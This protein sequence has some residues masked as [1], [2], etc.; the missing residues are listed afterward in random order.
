MA[1]DD[2][3]RDGLP[4]RTI[5]KAAA[6]RYPERRRPA[7]RA[8]MSL[9][10]VLAICVVMVPVLL[11]NNGRNLERLGD[12]VGLPL[13]DWWRGKMQRVQRPQMLQPGAQPVPQAVDATGPSRL[14]IPTPA[15]DTPP[16]HF[17]PPAEAWQPEASCNALQPGA[18]GEKPVFRAAPDG[19]SECTV[20]IAL[21]EGDTASSLFLQVRAVSDR[22]SSLRMK[23]NF[24]MDDQAGALAQKA[25]DLAQR[26]LAPMS[27]DNRAYLQGRMAERQAFRTEIGD[28]RM[29]F[30]A[31]GT[32]EARFNFI[33]LSRVKEQSSADEEQGGSKGDPQP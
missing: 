7:R 17:V 5:E 15:L 2:A 31:E 27:D 12:R 10:V 24:G 29:T 25:G 4:D 16:S 1:R 22:L 11:A 26:I 19:R 8:V 21:T 20:L 23:L 30:R 28:Y 9:F 32:D 33:A 6:E 3:D 14:K 13:N 18:T